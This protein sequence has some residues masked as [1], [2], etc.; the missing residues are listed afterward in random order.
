[1]SSTLKVGCGD[2]I[3]VVTTQMALALWLFLTSS[4]R[5]IKSVISWT[6]FAT[7]ASTL[8]GK[9]SNTPQ[10]YCCH[11]VTKELKI[12]NKFA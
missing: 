12:G 4:T 3:G 10:E 5:A 6:F 11:E 9:V 1:M 8:L 7:M 2:E